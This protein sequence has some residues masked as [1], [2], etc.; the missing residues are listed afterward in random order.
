MYPN[1]GYYTPRTDA[2]DIL[3]VGGLY[4]FE[5]LYAL[6]RFV[7]SLQGSRPKLRCGAA[8]QPTMPR[9][10][11]LRFAEHVP[12]Y[13]SDERPRRRDSE[14]NCAKA[15]FKWNAP[16]LQFALRVCPHPALKQASSLAPPVHPLPN[17]DVDGELPVRN[18]RSTGLRM[19]TLHNSD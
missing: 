12:A 9:A 19:R 4:F 18:Y 5:D 2:T 8:P 13:V 16:V 1:S 10:T 7:L 15:S 6:F 17:P 3:L 11:G 14:P